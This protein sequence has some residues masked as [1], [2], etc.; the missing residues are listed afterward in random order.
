MKTR[1]GYITYPVRDIEEAIAFYEGMIGFTVAKREDNAVVLMSGDGRK[2]RLT[3]NGEKHEPDLYN[4]HICWDVESVAKSAEILSEKGVTLYYGPPQFAPMVKEL[5]YVV[6]K[7]KCGSYSLFMMDPS[8]N[9]I[10]FHQITEQSLQLR[11]REE[12]IPLIPLIDRNEYIPEAK[13]QSD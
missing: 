11:T 12:I 1:F 9:I 6:P 13:R 8:G 5:P 7:G 4:F 3:Q 10:E 2:L